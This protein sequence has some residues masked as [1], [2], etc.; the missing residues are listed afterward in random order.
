MTLF[1]YFSISDTYFVKNFPR[2]LRSLEHFPPKIRPSLTSFSR[3]SLTV[4]RQW[5]TKG[6]HC[7]MKNLLPVPF[8]RSCTFSRWKYLNHV[9][10]GALLRS[11][12]TRRKSQISRQIKTSEVLTTPFLE[13]LNIDL[14]LTLLAH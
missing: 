3:T 2:F 8:G 1:T 9:T 12:D 10:F 7:A 6:Y 5:K 4:L 14:F 11:R 13:G